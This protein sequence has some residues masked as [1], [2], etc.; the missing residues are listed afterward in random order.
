MTKQNEWGRLK[1]F[2]PLGFNEFCEGMHIY[3]Y[4]NKLVTNSNNMNNEK[5]LLGRV[6]QIH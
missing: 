1:I 6:V 3:S 4:F 2:Y 5:G